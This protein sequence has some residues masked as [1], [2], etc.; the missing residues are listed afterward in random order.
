MLDTFGWIILAIIMFFGACGLLGLVLVIWHVIKT[1]KRW[2][3]RAAP[4]DSSH[5][6]LPI[7]SAYEDRRGW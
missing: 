3:S 4:I 6:D 7:P 2:L 5:D 1:V